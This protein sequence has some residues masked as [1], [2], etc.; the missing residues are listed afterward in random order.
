MS[1]L[2]HV[3]SWVQRVLLP[4]GSWGLFAAAVA[5]SSVIPL[6][7]GVDLWLITLCTQNPYR[8]S[9]YT[10]VASVG[11]VIGATALMYGVSKGGEAFLA[12]KLPSEKVE[13]AR[14]KIERSGFWALIVGG[15]LPPPTPFKLFIVAAGL[16]RFSVWKF[17]MA[18]L[19]GRL[20]RYSLE[21][22]LAVRYG[23]DAW[24][25]LL[26]AG[27]WTFVAVL[28]LAIIGFLIY[29]LSRAGAATQ[30]SL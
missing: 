28:L 17:M 5:D 23:H 14:R 10:L 29:K 19:V 25:L 26:H 6:P 16:L 12:R 9:L 4:L 15:L 1:W 3:T 8:A 18:L 27:P 21:A 13:E 2:N 11:S 24:Q 22:Y 7:S 30:S 20:I